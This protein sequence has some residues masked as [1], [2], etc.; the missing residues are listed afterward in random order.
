MATM[1]AGHL[2][3]RLEIPKAEQSLNITSLS[4]RHLPR[5]GKAIKMATKIQTAKSQK[6]LEDGADSIAN[7]D[8]QNLNMLALSTS[9]NQ[10][11]IA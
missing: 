6:T 8:F 2:L 11:D 3:Q 1:K 4:H 10:Q 9:R 5:N 7:P